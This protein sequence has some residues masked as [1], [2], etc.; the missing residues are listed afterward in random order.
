MSFNRY[1]YVNNNPYK[2]TDP[3]GEFIHMIVGAAIGAAIDAGLQTY[4]NYQS[5]QSLG[6]SISN[7]DLGSVAV[8][9]ALGASGAVGSQLIKGALTGTLKVGSQSVAVSSGV[10]RA[11]VGTLGVA[12]ASATGTAIA[13]VKGKSLSTGSAVQVANGVAPGLGSVSEL[14]VNKVME[15]ISE[16]DAENT[17]IDYTDTEK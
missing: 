6:E 17:D 3:D 7:V 10:E 4:K 8:S 12:N 15:S 16:S 11:V 2:Y 1:L 13:G 14:A 9:A 5:G